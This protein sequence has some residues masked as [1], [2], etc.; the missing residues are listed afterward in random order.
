MCPLAGP[1]Q[2]TMPSKCCGQFY[3]YDQSLIFNENYMRLCR[4]R[5]RVISD[6]AYKF[7]EDSRILKK[8]SES[9]RGIYGDIWRTL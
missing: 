2:F 1:R 6:T 3:R 7:V 5:E 8:L 9:S 4:D